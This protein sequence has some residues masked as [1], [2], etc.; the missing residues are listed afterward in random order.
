MRSSQ[1]ATLSELDLVSTP[2]VT[3][4]T[5][6]QNSTVMLIAAFIGPVVTGNAL[7][8]LYCACHKATVG[9]VRAPPTRQ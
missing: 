9:G 1:V 4:I 6:T 3:R 7:V 2:V 5:I 8:K